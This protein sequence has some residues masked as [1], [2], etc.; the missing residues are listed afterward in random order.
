VQYWPDCIINNPDTIEWYL[1]ILRLYFSR[2]KS[3]FAYDPVAG[4]LTRNYLKRIP[5]YLIVPVMI[6]TAAFAAL[7][8]TAQNYG[9]FSDELYFLAC[10]RHPELSYVDHPAF[11]GWI[12][13]LNMMFGSS[14]LVLRIF[15]ALASAGTIVLTAVISRA[16]GG[17]KFA[18]AASSMALPCG[19]VFWVMSGYVSMNAYDIL[20]V[21]LA[22]YLFI[23]VLRTDSLRSWMLLGLVIGLGLNTK[24]TMLIFGGGLAAGLLLFRRDLFF[25]RNFLI[26]AAIAA[27]MFLPNILWQVAHDWPTLEF[28]RQARDKNLDIS[29]VSLLGQLAFASNPLLLPLWAGGIVYLFRTQSGISLRPLGTAVILFFIA[30]LSQQSKFYYMLPVLPFLLAAG[31]A[32]FE[33]WTRDRLR[34]LRVIYAAPVLLLGMALLPFGLPLLSVDTFAAYARM[35]DVG[36][37]MHMEKNDA[38]RIPGYFG[39]RIGWDEFAKK[40]AAVYYSVPDSERTDCGILG[41]HYSDAGAVDYF[42]PSL[43]LPNA[44]SRHMSYWLWGPGKYSGKVMIVIYSGKIHL[45]DYFRNVK[46]KDTYEFPYVDDTNR[47]KY[48]FMCRDPVKPLPEM[49]KEM[50]TFR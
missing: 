19:T 36:S 33:H 48:I 13:R 28:I 50:K 40:V 2:L 20:F 12:T 4:M 10:A 35:W 42:G 18:A 31:A 22:A 3:N 7:L 1:L 8:V 25:S 37:R 26:A 9:V 11:V 6:A 49:W 5:E 21:T 27:G 14:L 29:P 46:L 23:V 15:P 38:K 45:K 43:G 32:G 39:Q 34:R 30:Y 44:I 24:M 47:M 41:F 17:A 16:L